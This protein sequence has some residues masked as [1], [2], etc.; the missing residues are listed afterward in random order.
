MIEREY[1]S[2]SSCD[3]DSTDERLKRFGYDGRV[4]GENLAGE[5]VRSVNRALRSNTG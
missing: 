2:H 4:H 5:P 3:G 1:F